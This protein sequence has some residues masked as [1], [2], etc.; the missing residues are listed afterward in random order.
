[1]APE[2]FKGGTWYKGYAA[3]MFSLGCILFM[4]CT[5]MPITEGD[6]TKED[7]VYKYIYRN[8]KRKFWKNRATFA[9]RYRVDLD[10]SAE[11]TS[12]IDDLVCFD[13]DNR[14]TLA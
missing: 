8:D 2:I 6:C 14:L 7:S 9:K 1:M 5:R 11:L 12:L 4:L 13:P 10:L 3:D